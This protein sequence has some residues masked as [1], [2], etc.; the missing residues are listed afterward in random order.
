MPDGPAHGP[1]PPSGFLAVMDAELGNGDCFGIYWPLGRE[2][3]EPVICDTAHDSWAMIPC[4]ANA[5]T[6]ADWLEANDYDRGDCDYQDSEFAPA[7]FEQGKSLIAKGA[8]EEAIAALENACAMFS[9]I[10]EYWFTLAGQLRRIGRQTDA[11][12]AAIRAYTANWAFGRPAEG[13]L[14]M[15]Q[16]GQNVPEL[17]Q[18]PLVKRS[19]L[20]TTRFGGEKENSNYGLLRECAREYLANG[21]RIS[22]LMLEQNFA[23]M[24][25]GETTSF[26]ERNGFVL[27]DWQSQFAKLCEEYLGNS[28]RAM[29]P[30]FA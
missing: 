27:K 1:Y 15:I 6:F 17:A 24:M 21:D 28:R 30:D 26:Q 9:E 8:V 4:F 11:I 19:K 25:Q 22:G 5:T 20:L 16:S 18:D 7:Y 3:D 14:R 29:T 10:A 13:V 23:L 2:G 12:R